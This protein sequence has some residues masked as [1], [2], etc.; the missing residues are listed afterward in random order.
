MFEL[1]PRLLA[2]LDRGDPVV[3]ATAVSMTGSAPSGVGTSMA[4]LPGGQV[5]GTI[6]GGCVEGSLF[7]TAE[8]V[9][10]TGGA[11]LERFGFDED[12]DDPDAVWAP[13]LRCGGR[14]EV[15]VRRIGPDDTLLV[16][17]LRDAA[18]GVPASVTLS[19]EAAT[20]GAVVTAPDGCRGRVF[21][22][23]ADHRPRCI[24]VGAV[25]TAVAVTNAAAVLGYAVTVVDPRPVFLT[26][27]RFPAAQER[28]VGW[29]NRVLRELPIDGTTVVVVL[30]HDDRFDADVIDLALRR[31]AGYVGAMGSRATHERRSETLRALGTPDLD[32]LRS[33]IGLDIGARTPAELAVAV[34]AEVVAV[35]T[36]TA[37]GALTGG[38]G[39]IHRSTAAAR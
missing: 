15:L 36:G 32:R 16:G 19:L 11:V 12:P 9:L 23:R 39:P 1:A 27:E 17:A 35:R 14:V 7:V 21:V 6:S 25:E 8:Q 24:V 30:S 10:E 5:V 18:R 34:M 26:D 38:A 31:G 20:L 13:A 3:V 33:P 4:V 2:V 22:E 28:I 29:P 37:G